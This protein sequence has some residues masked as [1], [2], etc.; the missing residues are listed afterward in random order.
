[1]H[2]ALQVLVWPN[3]VAA[4]AVPLVV[5]VCFTLFVSPLNKVKRVW[6]SVTHMLGLGR[7]PS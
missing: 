6:P 7:V 3:A 5:V 1:M 4:Y 2:V